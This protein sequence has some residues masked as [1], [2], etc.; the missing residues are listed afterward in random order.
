[1]FFPPILSFGYLFD[2]G[3]AQGGVVFHP[4]SFADT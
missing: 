1:V 3:L 2:L 4:S